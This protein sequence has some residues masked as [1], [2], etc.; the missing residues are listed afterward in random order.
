[1]ARQRTAS[2]PEGNPADV[3]ATMAGLAPLENADVFAKLR[4][5]PKGLS[6]AEAERRLVDH[7]PNAVA[8]EKRR[9]WLRRLFMAARNLLVLLLAVLAALSFATGD[10]RAGTVMA[11]M[12][13]LGVGLRFVQESRAE[14]GAAKLAAMIHVTAAVVR[15]GQEEEIPLKGLV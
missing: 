13:A 7:G 8:S 1:M 5:S 10:F 9:G 12:L 6:Q 15:E 3:S 14:A 11:L 2:K 4:T